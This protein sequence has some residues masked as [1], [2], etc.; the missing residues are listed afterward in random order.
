VAVGTGIYEARQAS[1]LRSQLQTLQQQPAPWTEQIQQLQRE[2]DDATS[3]LVALQKEN[4]EL[5]GNIEE[6][7][8]LRGEGARM[9]AGAPE[10]AQ[11]KPAAVDVNDPFI[12][13]VLAMT[14]RALELNQHLEQ[15]PNKKIPELQLLTESHVPARHGRMRTDRAHSGRSG[16]D[17]PDPP[18]NTPG[19]NPSTK[20]RGLKGRG[21]G[22]GP[23]PCWAQRVGR[24]TERS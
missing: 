9:R 14:A 24:E 11:L 2:R 16:S 17:P 15:M 21:P 6:L 5:R 8:K 1:T 23:R 22:R 12:R 13:S 7:A 3:K 10:Q 18:G 20:R 19:L 4:E